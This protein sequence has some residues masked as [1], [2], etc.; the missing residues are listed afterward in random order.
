MRAKRGAIS[1]LNWSSQFGFCSIKQRKRN[2]C[3]RPIRQQIY[4]FVTT[5]FGTTIVFSSR[6]TLWSPSLDPFFGI[7]AIARLESVC[8]PNQNPATSSN[9]ECNPDPTTGSV[10][11]EFVAPEFV[12]SEFVASH[13]PCGTWLALP[14]CPH[15]NHRRS[16]HPWWFFHLNSLGN[17]EPDAK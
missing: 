16:P 4:I 12:A 15:P 9:T 8:N 10:A 3:S 5:L 14:G 1:A 6:Q 7:S 11:S 13:L 2:D 17:A